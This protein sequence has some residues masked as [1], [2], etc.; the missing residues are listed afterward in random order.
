MANRVYVAV[1]GEKG[2]GYS[3]LGVFN[4]RDSAVNTCLSQ[5]AHFTGGWART[6]DGRWTND[7]DY[8]EVLECWTED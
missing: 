6:R 7:C 3:I 1:R 4:E 5:P 2:Q 8:V